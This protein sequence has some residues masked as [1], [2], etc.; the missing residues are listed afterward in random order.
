MYGNGATTG[1]TPPRWA[2]RAI[3][4]DRQRAR[5]ECCAAVPG[6]API[7]FTSCVPH[8]AN[9]PIP[10]EDT[11]ATGFVAF[12]DRVKRDLEKLRIA[13]LWYLILLLIFL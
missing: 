5:T 1:M 10:R 13:F 2:A 8:T 4:P 11:A 6:T 3:R 12:G 7:T 9:T